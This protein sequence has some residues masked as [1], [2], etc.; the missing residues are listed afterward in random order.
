[1]DVTKTRIQNQGK[2]AGQVPKYNWAWP[3][4]FTIAREEGLVALW[5]GFVP[6]V[7]RLGPGLSLPVIRL[8]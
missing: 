3:A 5:K 7:L 1:M 8:K 2:I 6:K 4:V